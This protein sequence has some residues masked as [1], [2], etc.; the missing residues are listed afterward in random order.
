MKDTLKFL[1]KIS[2]N[3]LIMFCYGFLKTCEVFWQYVN[4][5][6]NIV[7]EKLKIGITVS[8]SVKA[9]RDL[10]PPS[11]WKWWDWNPGGLSDLFKVTHRASKRPKSRTWVPW[12]P[13]LFSVRLAI[14]LLTIW[15]VLF[16]TGQ[17][18]DCRN[19]V[20]VF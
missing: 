15:I 10:R 14:F 11:C 6:S 7:R 17:N 1:L 4:K 19:G 20:S 16:C 18:T 2:V 8:P 13:V 12:L 5:V 3:D 9:R